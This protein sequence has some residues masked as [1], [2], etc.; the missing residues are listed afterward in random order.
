MD[1]VEH[2]PTPR[3][4][5]QQHTELAQFLR[6]MR[7]RLAPGDVG[8][9]ETDRRR[10]P[11]LRRQEVA[12]LAAVSI[13]WYI[14]LEQGRVG[15]PGAAVLD[16]LAEAL[17]LSPA[18]RRH[19]HVIAR[20]ESPVDGHVPLPVA[21]SLRV[22]LDGMP[23]LP[24]YL[25]DFRLDVQAHNAAAAALFGEDFGTGEADNI[26]RL[27]FLAPRARAMQLDWTQ[28]ARETVGNL[29]ANLARHRDDPRLRE[30][31]TELRSESA[32]F[33]TWWD[34]HTVR[35]R[36]HGTKRLHHP[37]VGGLTVHYDLLATLQGGEH[38]L[39][40]VTPADTAAEL[41]LREMLVNRAT[42]LTRPD[43]RALASRTP[44]PDPDTDRGHPAERRPARP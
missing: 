30:V 12:Q 24:A 8:L 2:R 11:G 28:V 10:T 29:R 33:R 14:R 39:T 38:C 7:A 9:P 27:L 34:D 18:E 40:V 21:D 44:H 19:L 17:R 43:V 32:E 16:A 26:A 6:A 4:R 35:Q 3:R 37:T 23:L 1:G 20:G 42:S 15:T 25:V 22:L 31:I 41:S 36:A 13:D 5:V